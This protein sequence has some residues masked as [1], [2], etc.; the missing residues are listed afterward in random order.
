MR[1]FNKPIAQ[2]FRRK[3]RIHWRKGVEI[4]QL[5]NFPSAYLNRDVRVD[6]YLPPGH[7]S[8]P[9]VAGYPFLIF[10]DGQDL[11][12]VRLLETLEDLWRMARLP[13]L[14]A[15]GIHAGDRM[16]EYGTAH[17]PDYLNRGARAD[18]YAQFIIR[19]LLP[20]LRQRY[21]L[22]SEMTDAAIA[23]FSLGGLSALDIAWQYPGVF[24]K[25]GIFSGS[26]WWRSKAFRP[27][28][29]DAD[30]IAHELIAQGPYRVDMK[31]WLQT[32]T[33]DET[34][35]RN[36]NG[37]IDSIDDTLDLISELKKLGYQQGADIRY[38]EIEGGEHNPGTW[39]RAMGDFLQ[40]SFG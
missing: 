35:D 20:T 14:I 26:L 5:E 37:I 12:A 28:A 11:E 29:P 39:A 32:G 10:N 21:H 16:Q 24:T 17:Q 7:F 1:L 22:S 18:D 34:A 33:H 19:E 8:A 38:V 30:R 6:V 9:A 3:S 36:N 15:V 27:E 13:H 40:W 2:L 4:Q 23:G 31:F 25:V